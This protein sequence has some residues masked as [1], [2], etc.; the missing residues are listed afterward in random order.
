MEREI[1]ETPPSGRSSRGGGS[2]AGDGLRSGQ[3][4]GGPGAPTADNDG[5][6]NAF[7]HSV[8]L[9]EVVADHSSRISTG[10]GELDRALGGGLVVGSTVLVGG[11]PGIGKSTLMLQM[12]G[13]V[14]RTGTVLYI[15]G[16]EN[17]AQ[18]RRRAERLN[19][20][21]T[22]ISLLCTTS[23]DEILDELDG[24][25]PRLVVID[26]V[27]TMISPDAGT[28]PGTVNQ[29]KYITHQIAE[30]AHRSGGT[31]IMVAH[32]TKE[33]Q[34]AGP[35]VVEHLVDAVL[36]FEHSDGELRFLRATKN[37]FGAIEELGIFTMESNGLI[38]LREPGRLFLGT[39]EGERPAGVVAAPCY[40]GSRVLLV[41]IQALTVAAKGAV[42]R[43]FSERIDTRRVGRVAAVLEKH[44]GVR[45]SDQDVYVNVAG[46]MRIQ[47][48][49]ID[50][51]LALAL[52]S[53]RTGLAVPAGMLATGELT[54]AG[55]VRPVTHR[56][57]REKAA[58]DMGFTRLVGPEGAAGPSGSIWRSVSTISNAIK[59]VFGAPKGV[60]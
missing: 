55:E 14:S 28:V 49:A 22:Q 31:V 33:G 45:F 18:I 20:S 57:Q 9:S 38:E 46:G 4:G 26:S 53:A 52:Y 23:M 24:L 39:A 10:I 12:A 54:L 40:E 37:R 19:V 13:E 60:S 59:S 16:E 41:E 25:Q 15:S 29:I 8:R 42:S 48:V 58:L 2:A 3:S 1:R 51:P 21:D 44:A 11:E 17:I 50:L 5:R 27:Q 43:S 56:G 30:W 34:I 47:D 6:G 32:V 7:L 35:K 36:L